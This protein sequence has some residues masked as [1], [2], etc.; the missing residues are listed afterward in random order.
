MLR[1][2]AAVRPDDARDRLADL[3]DRPVAE[4]LEAD[5][6]DS[7]DAH[8]LADRRERCTRPY[9]IETRRAITCGVRWARSSRSVARGRRRTR[10]A[11]G[12]DQGADPARA[13]RGAAAATATSPRSP[14]SSSTSSPA[15]ASPASGSSSRSATST[16]EAI[17]ERRRHVLTRASRSTR[18][19]RRS[20]SRFRGGALDRP[21]APLDDPHRSVA[22]AGRARRSRRSRTTQAARARRSSARTADDEPV[23]APGRRSSVGAPADDAKLAHARTRRQ[24]HAVRRSPRK[25]P[26]A[27][28][29]TASARRS[30]A[31]TRARPRPPRR[32]SS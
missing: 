18:A 21:A 1:L 31:T 26:A 12:R 20:R 6:L 29:R 15:R 9:D 7:L 5:D 4:R 8:G 2:A 10:R 25:A 19:R 28:A 24:R 13:R 23:T 14:A 30:P 16:A 32:R 17:T 11:A 3:D 27:P 22:R